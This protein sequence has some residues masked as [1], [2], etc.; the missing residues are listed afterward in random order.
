MP[1]KNLINPIMSR[2]TFCTILEAIWKGKF[3]FQEEL[4]LCIY[5]ETCV[6]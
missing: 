6:Q 3:Y 1:E 4:K 5:M 2:G